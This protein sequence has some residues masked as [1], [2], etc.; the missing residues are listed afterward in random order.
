MTLLLFIC[1]N[2]KMVGNMFPMTHGGT[3][4][5]RMNRCI[6]GIPIQNTT[7]QCHIFTIFF[8]IDNSK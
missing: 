1:V 3:R 7:G 5:G 6:L 2:S 4:T 8:F